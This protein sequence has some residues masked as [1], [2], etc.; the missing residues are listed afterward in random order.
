M[1]SL[2]TRG[3]WGCSVIIEI[4]EILYF[5]LLPLIVMYYLYSFFWTSFVRKEVF[6]TYTAAACDVITLFK[7]T[8]MWIPALLIIMLVI[9][10][11]DLW[12]H[13]WTYHSHSQ[14]CCC[15]CHFLVCAAVLMKM[16]LLELKRCLLKG[17]QLSSAPWTCTDDISWGEG[18]VDT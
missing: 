11:A 2:N 6:S 3:K 4:S 13:G 10:E 18:H 8:N 17:S 12:L 5:Y 15:C 14:C 1:P 16:M 9:H 7:E